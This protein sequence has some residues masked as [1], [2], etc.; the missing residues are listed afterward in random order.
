MITASSLTNGTLTV[1]V[2]NGEKILTAR[3]D[4][5]RWTDIQEAYKTQ[6]SDLLLSLISLQAVVENYSVGTLSVNAT[7]VIYNGHSLHTVD[8]VRVMSFLREGLPFKPIANYIA[9]KM[10]NPSAR[11]ITEM[12]TFLEHKNMPLTPDGFIVA[13]KGVNEDFYSV[14][15]NTETIV[16]QGKVNSK[17][18]IWNVIGATIEVERR[19]VDD[20]FRKGCSHGLHAGSVDY[21]RGWGKRIVLVSIDPADVVSV[22]EDCECQKLRC[23]KYKVIGEYTGPMPE[24]YTSE[25]SESSDSDTTVSEDDEDDSYEEYELEHTCSDC[26]SNE[27]SCTC[28]PDECENEDE[29]LSHIIPSDEPQSLTMVTKDLTKEVKDFLDNEEK[30]QKVSGTP[31]ELNEQYLAG[32]SHGRSDHTNRYNPNYIEGD[33]NG[34]DSEEH[35]SYIAGYVYGY[36]ELMSLSDKKSYEKGIKDGQEETGFSTYNSQNLIPILDSNTR[37]YI[38]GY[39]DGYKLNS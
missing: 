5:P 22:P 19:C 13:Y 10:K 30:I 20:D 27:C 15:A 36:G 28:K 9:R 25:F 33:Q 7:G 34:A 2:N 38:K 17:G 31:R 26:G 1:I 37:C 35:R 14:M 12:Y 6:N 3:N 32:A 4:H 11:A 24:T 39:L 23:C 18:Q 8:S 21:A 16:L 29:I